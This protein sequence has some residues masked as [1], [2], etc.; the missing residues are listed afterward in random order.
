M[1]KRTFLFSIAAI[2]AILFFVWAEN[3]F[4][5]TFQA[6]IRQNT[7]KQAA[8]S[9][10]D[11]SFIVREFMGSQIVCTISLIDRHNGFFAA[12][13]ALFVAGFTGTFWR[14]TEKL[15]AASIGQG[16]AMERSIAEAEKSAK[17][18]SSVAEFMAKNVERLK[19]TVSGLNQSVDANKRIVRAYLTIGVGDFYEQDVSKNAPLQFHPVV[20]NT[21]NTPALDVIYNGRVVFRDYPPGPN[22]DFTMLPINEERSAITVGSRQ[23]P[24]PAIP[25]HADR[26]F[27][28]EE[29]AEAKQARTKRLYVFGTVTYKD[30]FG[31]PHYTDFCQSVTWS[32]QG[33]PQAIWTNS[34]MAPT[35][36]RPKANACPDA[37][38]TKSRQRKRGERALGSVKF[39]DNRR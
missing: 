29:M 23:F 39:R 20:L 14:S 38:S 3:E 4:G 18:M 22:F 16:D 33:R 24:P 21:G 36:P 34:T 25:V 17:A 15:W 37:S 5:P 6:C 10:K 7:N 32:I 28:D 1:L 12:V 26:W 2:I 30:V 9:A 31:V 27:T 19:E 11:Q 35:I 13:A 8:E